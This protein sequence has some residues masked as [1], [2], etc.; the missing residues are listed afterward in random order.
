MSNID[1]SPSSDAKAKLAGLSKSRITIQHLN[2]KESKEHSERMG[3]PTSNLL[4]G[5]TI[6]GGR[7]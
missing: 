1:Q 3:W 2:A 5:N 7:K 6:K 4:I